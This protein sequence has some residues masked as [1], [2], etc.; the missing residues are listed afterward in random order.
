MFHAG[1][2]LLLGNCCEMKENETHCGCRNL[3][4]SYVHK[5]QLSIRL[6]NGI[7]QYEKLLIRNGGGCVY[8]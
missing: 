1:W 8:G 4:C 3:H 2:D 6:H 5:L 7:L